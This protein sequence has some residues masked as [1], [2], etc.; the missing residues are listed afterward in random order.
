ML[1]KTLD[2]KSK[3]KEK[4]YFVQWQ[5]IMCVMNSKKLITPRLGRQYL[6]KGSTEQLM[7]SICSTKEGG[8]S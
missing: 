3:Y 7:E 6:Q 1:I 5:I 2:F 4:S 8:I